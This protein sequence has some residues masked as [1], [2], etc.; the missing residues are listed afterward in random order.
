MNHMINYD[1]KFLMYFLKQFI[2]NR[3]NQLLSGD[4]IKFQ[5]KCSWYFS[6]PT[7]IDDKLS[8]WYIFF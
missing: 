2:T 5:G 1:K 6:K 8:M 7:N 3:R 4:D